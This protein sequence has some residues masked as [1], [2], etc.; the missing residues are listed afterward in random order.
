VANASRPGRHSFG[1]PAATLDVLVL[2]VVLP[3]LAWCAPPRTTL[4]RRKTIMASRWSVPRIASLLGLVTMSA[5]GLAAPPAS[6]APARTGPA[7]QHI[8]G[9][10]RIPDGDRPAGAVP[11]SARVSGTVVLRPRDNAALVR[12]IAAVTDKNSPEFHQYLPAG[13]F[14]SRF[15]PRQSSINAVRAQLRADG[16]AVS[17]VSGDGLLMSFSGTASRVETAFR[18]GLER[19]TLSDGKTG[20]ATTSAVSVPRSIAS[21]VTAVLGL[22]A[23]VQLHPVGLDRATAADRGQIR[24]AATASFSHP[25][26]SPTACPA[27]SAAALSSGGL[28]DD[29]IAHAYGAFGLYGSGDTGA[30]QHIALYELEPFARSDIR[31]FDTCYFG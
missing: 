14:A 8:Q 20:Q 5:V 23:L 25:A 30:G 6:A 16:L 31:V 27:A 21:S 2:M 26:G 28:T 9:A 1:F 18:T 3:I 17:G 10:P 12:F 24:P 29:Q 19:Y 22:N 15:G 4:D 7:M 11:A 13:A